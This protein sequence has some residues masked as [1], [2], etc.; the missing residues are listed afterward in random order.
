MVPFGFLL[1]TVQSVT[2]CRLT[3]FTLMLSFTTPQDGIGHARSY[4]NFS[5]NGFS[6]IMLILR[7]SFSNMQ[8]WF[9]VIKSNHFN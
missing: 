4:F 1:I 6:E 2:A 5:G 3:G 9:K 7:L 8:Q